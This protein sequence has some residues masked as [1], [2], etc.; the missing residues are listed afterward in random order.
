MLAAAFAFARL[1]ES[2]VGTADGDWAATAFLLKK[3]QAQ[4]LQFLPVLQDQQAQIS[5]IKSQP[6]SHSCSSLLV[7]Q[8][9]IL[10]V[11]LRSLGLVLAK[12]FST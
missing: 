11:R 12:L 10:Q 8:Y 3:Q 6:P 7:Q 1:S 5:Q 9:L 4:L 2:W